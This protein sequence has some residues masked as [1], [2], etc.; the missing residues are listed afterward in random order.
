M[1]WLQE[2]LNPGAQ[3]SSSRLRLALF[4]SAMLCYVRALFLD[5]ILPLASKIDGKSSYLAL[6]SLSICMRKNTSFQSSS[7]KAHSVS[8]ALKSKWTNLGQRLIP[9]P[10]SITRGKPFN[11]YLNPIGWE[12]NNGTFSRGK[13]GC[14][15]QKMEW[16]EYLFTTKGKNKRIQT[17]FN[18]GHWKIKG[19]KNEVPF[20]LVLAL[21]FH[22]KN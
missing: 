10:V 1:I 13:S 9:A 8:E 5:C 17:E 12:C 11:V 3:K 18:E 4:I 21:H 16:K 14:C 15:N 7:P 22:Y 19:D 6:Q 2:Q 20:S